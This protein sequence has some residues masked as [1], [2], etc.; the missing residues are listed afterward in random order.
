MRFGAEGGPGQQALRLLGGFKTSIVSESG[1]HRRLG[2]GKGHPGR[3]RSAGGAGSTL[4][5]DGVALVLNEDNPPPPPIPAPVASR[6]R[7]VRRGIA[8]GLD[9]ALG[10]GCG[11][12]TVGVR[13]SWFPGREG[14]LKQGLLGAAVSLPERSLVVPG[15][16]F[17]LKD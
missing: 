15:S 4:L 14:A 2:G 6:S 3:V 17:S 1:E 7:G 11:S 5:G 8:V 9:T 16:F 12:H 13:G 10:V